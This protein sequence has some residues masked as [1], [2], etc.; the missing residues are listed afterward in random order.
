[1]ATYSDN[2]EIPIPLVRRHFPSTG[3]EAI[4]AEE[5]DRSQSDVLYAIPDDRMTP[6][7]AGGIAGLFAGMAA[8]GVVHGLEAEA[9]GRPIA[10]VATARGVDLAVTFTIAYVTAGAIGSLVGATFAVVTRYLRKWGPLLLW[11]LVFFV[12]LAMLLLAASSAYGRGV[13]VPLSGPILAASAAYG[14][15]VSFSLPIRRRR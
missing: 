9:L 15:V 7:V 12:S 5:D 6:A 14:F 11:A 13:G 8:L 2:E 1:M 10:A 3:T 4:E